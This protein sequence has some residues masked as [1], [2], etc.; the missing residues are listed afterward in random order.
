MQPVL[1]ELLAAWL[2]EKPLMDKKIVTEAE[3][4]N[5]T[6]EH[7]HKSSIGRADMAHWPNHG[8]VMDREP[9]CLT[10]QSFNIRDVVQ[11]PVFVTAALK[12]K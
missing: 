12:R 2:R 4:L 11:P 3:L 1:E 6:V 9:E 10:L 5:G 7:I 8:P